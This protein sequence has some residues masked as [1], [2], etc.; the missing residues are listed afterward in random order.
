MTIISSLLF[1]SALEAATIYKWVDKDGHVHYGSRAQSKAAKKLIIK[2]HKVD[3]DANDTP[4]DKDEKSI[5][6]KEKEEQR[7]LKIIRCNAAKDQLKRYENSGA[8]YDLNEKGNR[9]LL[10]K[11]QYEQA[12]TQAKSRVKKWCN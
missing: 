5:S 6:E 7:E 8:L 12:M 2:K 4:V 3:I 10:H 9:I 11:K 1:F